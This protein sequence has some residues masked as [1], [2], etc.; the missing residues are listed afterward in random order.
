MTHPY[1]KAIVP[2]LPADWLVPDNTEH[3]GY[4][5][6]P[7]DDQHRRCM[8]RAVEDIRAV[9]HQFAGQHPNTAEAK[10]ANEFA[11][12]LPYLHQIK[13]SEVAFGFTHAG[14]DRATLPARF[15]VARSYMAAMDE[16]LKEV[17]GGAWPSTITPDNLRQKLFA[18]L[19][20][21]VRSGAYDMDFKA[22]LES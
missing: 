8:L 3:P 1:P 18:A 9:A 21:D 15:A 11:S 14:V 19:V 5:T 16:N 12:H 4:L 6:S 7:L 22:P 20:S 13:A 17:E 10:S 2:T